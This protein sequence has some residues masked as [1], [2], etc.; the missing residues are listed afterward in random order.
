MDTGLKIKTLPVGQMKSNCYLIW[1]EDKEA[2]IIDPGDDGDYIATTI[3]KLELTPRIMLATHGHFDHIMAAL[4]LKL[5]YNLPFYIHDEDEFLVDRMSDSAIHFLGFDPGPEP[6]IDDFLI[7]KAH[8]KAGEID[9]KI[10]HTPGHTPGSVT[11]Y[12]EN[13]GVAFVGDVVF[14]DGNV[15]RTDFKYSNPLELSKSI[16]TIEKL[17]KGTRI[18]PGH[19]QSFLL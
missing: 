1:D 6:D 5:A 2:I 13:N 11:L 3:Q 9:L 4:E 18:Y 10:I 7:N 8:I 19:D 12:E 14:S 16:Q 17:P 15:G